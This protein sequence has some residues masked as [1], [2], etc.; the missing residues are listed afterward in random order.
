MGSQK[1]WVLVGMVWETLRGYSSGIDWGCPGATGLLRWSGSAQGLQPCWDG[2]GMPKGYSLVGDMLSFGGWRDTAL[3]CPNKQLKLLFLQALFPMGLR[4]G[5]WHEPS[6]VG[7]MVY[8]SPASPARLTV[9]S[10][11]C[12]AHI[13]G[14]QEWV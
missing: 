9:D 3:W 6:G 4:R 10:R 2:L 11:S 8:A 14:S 12:H 13:R 7:V 5:S 1:G